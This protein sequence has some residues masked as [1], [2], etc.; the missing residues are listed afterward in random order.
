[1]ESKSRGAKPESGPIRCPVAG[2]LDLLGDRWTL[3]VVRDLLVGKSRYGEFQAS[4]EGI[5]TNI[6]AERLKRLEASGIV[7]RVAYRERPLRHEYRLTEKGQELRG[8]VRALREWGLKNIP[9]TSVPKD[10]EREMP[11]GG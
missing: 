8:V 5:P 6:L 10:L 9:G 4:L 7:E 11:Q 1:M 2:A 3:V